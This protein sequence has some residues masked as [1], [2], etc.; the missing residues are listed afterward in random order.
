MN[1]EADILQQRAKLIAKQAQFRSDDDAVPISRS[2]ATVFE[3]RPNGK[4]SKHD[5][6]LLGEN[7]WN[8]AGIVSR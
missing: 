1:R 3:I 8:L 2:V 7:Y 6:N 5:G 4:V